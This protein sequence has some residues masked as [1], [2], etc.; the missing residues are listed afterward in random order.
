MANMGKVT[1]AK[2]NLRIDLHTC[3]A[4]EK[5]YSHPGDGNKAIAYIRA[6][7]DA[8][9]SVILDA[10][11]YRMILAEIASNENKSCTIRKKS[12]PRR[13]RRE[14]RSALYMA[15]VS[16]CHSNHV[17]EPVYKRFTDRGMPRRVALIALARHIAILM[18]YIAKY[19]DFNPAADPKKA[20]LLA[21][22]K[23]KPGRPRKN[24]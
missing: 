1:K 24:P 11:D 14:L 19:P 7:E 16:A 9:R 3:R 8:T 15:A 10:E 21:L 20:A 2:I 4:V 23:R 22:P 18:N 6:L 13:G 5:K 17:L 12:K